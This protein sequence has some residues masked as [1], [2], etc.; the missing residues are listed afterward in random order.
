[1]S[2]SPDHS[3]DSRIDCNPSRL[4]NTLDDPYE[5]YGKT[6]HFYDSLQAVVLDMCGP[7]TVPCA[8]IIPCP[9][10]SLVTEL[11]SKLRLSSIKN[12]NKKIYWNESS[13]FHWVV[14]CSSV[15]WQNDSATVVMIF[16]FGHYSLQ[17][18]YFFW[19]TVGGFRRSSKLYWV[20][21]TN[22]LPCRLWRLLPGR[23]S[24]HIS[25]A[26][27]PAQDPLPHPYPPPPPPPYPLLLV[28]WCQH[29]DPIFRR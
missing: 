14:H 13:M 11:C 12:C 10:S 23:F 20:A 19:E 25:P 16:W 1:M 3:N 17:V 29:C 6:S 24:W 2:S 15:H 26:S 22:V 8:P 9:Q 5:S 28:L 7:P 18:R 21:I 27:D 4:V